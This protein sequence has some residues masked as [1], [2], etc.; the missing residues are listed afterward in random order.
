MARP[1]KALPV[2]DRTKY[3][4]VRGIVEMGRVRTLPDV[5]KNAG[6][7]IDPFDTEVFVSNAGFTQHLI[8]ETGTMLKTDIEQILNLQSGTRMQIANRWT[9]PLLDYA[10]GCDEFIADSEGID[11]TEEGMI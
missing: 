2:F 5:I 4:V 1:A 9:S 10:L 7:R 8:I 11:M 3:R 6:I